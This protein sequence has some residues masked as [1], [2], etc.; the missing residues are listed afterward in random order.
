MQKQIL[1]FSLI[2]QAH[3]RWRW[4]SNIYKLS[5]NCGFQNKMYLLNIESTDHL[6]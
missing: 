1:S 6:Q 3:A 2:N 5:E 4:G